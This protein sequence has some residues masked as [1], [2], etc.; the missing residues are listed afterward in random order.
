MSYIYLNP[1]YKLKQDGNRVIL[2]GTENDEF[3]SDDWFS[4]IHPYHAIMF[5]FFKGEKESIYEIQEMADFFSLSY[6]EAEA[7]VHGYIYNKQRRLYASGR[8]YFFPNN[9]LLESKNKK[10]I[11]TNNYNPSDFTFNG[12]PDLS[13]FRTTSPISI[14]LEL[15]MD[16]Y[17]DC[18]YCYANRRLINKRTMSTEEIVNFIYH[19]KQSGVLNF[20]INGGE[21]MKHPGIYTILDTLNNC[22]YHP[23]ISTKMPLTSNQLKKLGNCGI[24]RFQISLDSI[25]ETIL[26]HTI[27]VKH[28]YVVAIE[29]T[30]KTADAQGFKVGINVVLTQ[31]N[32]KPRI[33]KELLD[34][35][36]KFSCIDTVRLNVCGYSIYKKAENFYKIRPSQDSVNTIENL[37]KSDF[38]INYSFNIRMAGYDKENQYCCPSDRQEAFNN[39]AICTGNL[40]NIVVLPNG[41]VTICEELYDN[42]NFIIGNILD[43]SLDKIWNGEKALDLFYNPCNKD[44]ESRCVRC[45]DLK[46]CRSSVG[47]CWKTVLMAYGEENWDYPD[48]RCPKAPLPYNEIYIK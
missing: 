11:K 48:P 47:I 36:Q 33:I 14:N 35:L 24:K 34:F 26:E 3:Q 6:S 44:S 16:C 1:E 13:T 31:Y 12:E 28:G 9:V 29:N 21:V 25:N 10:S 39:R 38:T 43:S 42:P 32:C 37:I 23:L 18:C 22:G 2:Y 27:K 30:L 41:D 5:S 46:N 17:T 45:E 40:R 4:F 7:I 19:A 15:T 8:Y 20:D